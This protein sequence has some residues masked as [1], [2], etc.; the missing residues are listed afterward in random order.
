MEQQTTHA[1][2]QQLPDVY[3]STISVLSSQSTGSIV[4]MGEIVTDVAESL[5]T[6][7][8]PPPPVAVAQ[9]QQEQ[10][11]EQEQEV[12]LFNEYMI[13]QRHNFPT[14][15]RD[16]LILE[17]NQQQKL[18]SSSSAKYPLRSSS[19]SGS[20][21]GHI[22]NH[23][24]RHPTESRNLFLFGTATGSIC[25]LSS[26]VLYFD[27]D[28]VTQLYYW[29][30]DK[31]DGLYSDVVSSWN[32]TSFDRWNVTDQIQA[33]YNNTNSTAIN[34]TTLAVRACTCT[35]YVNRPIE[36]CSAEFLSCSIRTTPVQCFTLSSTDTFIQ[37]FWP[38][39]IFWMLVVMYVWSCSDPGRIARQ[40]LQRKF[41]CWRC[42]SNCLMMQG[43]THTNTS[44]SPMEGQQQQQDQQQQLSN[45]ILTDDEL[46]RQQLDS[47][48]ENYPA[49]ANF[50]YREAINRHNRQ[51]RY[52]QQRQ[53]YQWYRTYQRIKQNIRNF[54]FCYR[55]NTSANSNPSPNNDSESLNQRASVGL[56][57]GEDNNMILTPSVTEPSGPRLLLKTK[58]YRFDDVVSRAAI[59]PNQKPLSS[60]Q[61]LGEIRDTL[62]GM[63]QSKESA[64]SESNP[65]DDDNSHNYC[66]ATDGD[67]IRC[68]ICLLP[69][70]DG[71]DIIGNL[72]CHH[73]MH[74]DCLKEW[75]MR[76]NRCP[77]CQ[78]SDVAEFQ[79]TTLPNTTFV[80]ST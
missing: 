8:S 62:S 22:I 13:L 35:Q 9:K 42:R 55:W 25:S 43:N 51:Q 71:I 56:T 24:R 44:E 70:Q 11:Q 6:Q 76:K 12:S 26:E 17:T 41:R 3:C 39:T 29:N 30:S 18:L 28:P 63:V 5:T 77:L 21:P 34:I 36:F 74:K 32:S 4:M 15:P 60:E 10:E 23:L 14:N 54:I 67:E 69:L 66:H 48:I 47:M 57:T 19:S 58:V 59:D 20:T 49:R 38:I 16:D 72:P 37:S 2:T 27:Q 40:Y 80:N 45:E 68:A 65:M 64:I 33:R 46:V 53:S 61:H 31:N 78:L 73:C 52:E 7:L 50:M 79:N 75:L 1:T